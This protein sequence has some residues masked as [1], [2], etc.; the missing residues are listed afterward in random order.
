MLLL[1]RSMERSSCRSG[2]ATRSSC[3]NSRSTVSTFDR[4]RVWCAADVAAG[5]Q[6]GLV[7]HAPGT[8][9]NG[10]PHELGRE[11]SSNSARQG[12]SSFGLTEEPRFN[13]NCEQPRNRAPPR[14]R[15][16]RGFFL[17][18]MGIQTL[19]EIVP[20]E[21]LCEGFGDVDLER[22]ERSLRHDQIRPQACQIGILF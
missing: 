4:L 20:P 1:A 15:V 22:I 8:I 14:N 16:A 9:K 3:K 19:F 2:W 21:R 11:F 12:N 6:G 10:E 5:L 7:T 18:V 17:V 13:G